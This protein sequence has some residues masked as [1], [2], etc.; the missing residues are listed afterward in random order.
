M[1]ISMYMGYA[2]DQLQAG[3]FSDVC[4]AFSFY[5]GCGV[6]YADI[7]DIE[8]AE[9]PMHLYCDYL[10]RVGIVPEALVTMTDIAS[11]DEKER[12]KNM[13]LVKGYIDQ[14]EKLKISV[15]MPAPDV[16]GARS[17]EELQRTREFFWRAF[18]S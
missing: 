10:Q 9:L 17:A 4:E 15:L 5:R 11:S 8:L 14:M 12:A 7:V 6:Q 16:R 18:L 1:E 13:A 2:L 3:D